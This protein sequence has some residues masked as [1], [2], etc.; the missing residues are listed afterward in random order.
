MGVVG[1]DLV[2]SAYATYRVTLRFSQGV[3]SRPQMGVW[4][5]AVLCCNRHGQGEAKVEAVNS[6]LED[7]GSQ[8]RR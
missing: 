6:E 5:R 7:I 3:V 8:S 2:D 4:Y 1:D